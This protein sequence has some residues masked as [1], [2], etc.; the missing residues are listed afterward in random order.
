[1]THGTRFVRQLVHRP[2]GIT[3]KF[4]QRIIRFSHPITVKMHTYKTQLLTTSFECTQGC[5]LSTVV[6][7]TKWGLL[8][9]VYTNTI[10]TLSTSLLTKRVVQTQT[11]YPCTKN[12]EVPILIIGDSRMVG[13]MLYLYQIRFLCTARCRFLKR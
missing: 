3:M 4:P 11:V 5:A 12:P 6:D 1:M 9:Y 13:A 2:R 8:L 10:N 7:A